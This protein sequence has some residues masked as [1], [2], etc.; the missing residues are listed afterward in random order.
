MQNHHHRDLLPLPAANL[1]RTGAEA[2]Q[3]RA[4]GLSTVERVQWGMI[5]VAVAVAALTQEFIETVMALLQRVQ[6]I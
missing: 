3:T 4:A 5:Q 1:G 6:G 2:E